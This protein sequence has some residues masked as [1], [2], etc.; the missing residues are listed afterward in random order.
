M[1]GDSGGGLKG[2]F[3]GKA[4]DRRRW[5]AEASGPSVQLLDEDLVDGHV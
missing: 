2:L 3:E 5:E 4:G 1:E